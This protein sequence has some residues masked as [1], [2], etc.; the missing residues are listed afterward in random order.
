MPFRRK[1]QEERK[2]KEGD[3]GTYSVNDSGT[4]F[5]TLKVWH[6]FKKNDRE[7]I[8][9]SQCQARGN[10]Y[11][12]IRIWYP[13]ANTGE[14]KPGKGLCFNDELWREFKEGIEKVDKD[15]RI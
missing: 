13:D 15:Y 5:K 12:D 9:F 11:I 8:R 3:A 2:A 10:D 6:V 4:G 14:M 1:T 7:E